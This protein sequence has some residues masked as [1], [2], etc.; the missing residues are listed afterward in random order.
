MLDRVRI[1][2]GWVSDDGDTELRDLAKLRSGDLMPSFA[3]VG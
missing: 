2:A 1:E 3:R